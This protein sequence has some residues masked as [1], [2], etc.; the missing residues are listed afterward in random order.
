MRDSGARLPRGD[1]FRSERCA[2]WQGEIGKAIHAPDATL[3]SVA[4]LAIQ[5]N[6][7]P[8]PRSGRQEWLEK[9]VNRF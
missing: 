5:S 4:E 1:A 3:A 7:A 6:R 8:E 9:L 2:G